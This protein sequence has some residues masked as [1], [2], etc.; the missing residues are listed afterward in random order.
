MNVMLCNSSLFPVPWNGAIMRLLPFNPSG[1]ETYTAGSDSVGPFDYRSVLLYDDL[2]RPKK[3]AK[4]PVL[5]NIQNT[6]MRVGGDGG[7]TEMDY[8]KMSVYFKCKGLLL[9]YLVRESKLF[10]NYKA[11]AGNK[12]Q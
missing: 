6:D 5:I 1:E 3:N 12:S 7:P 10:S 8:S 11:P 2:A 4:T 9:L